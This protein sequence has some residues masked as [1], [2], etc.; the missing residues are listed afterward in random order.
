MWKTRA[1]D[2]IIITKKWEENKWFKREVLK[3]DQSVAIIKVRTGHS[4]D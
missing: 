2:H 4:S 1:R 3:T